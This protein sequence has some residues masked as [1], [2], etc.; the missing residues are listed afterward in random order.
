M[1]RDAESNRDRVDLDGQ[2]KGSK[3]GVL[4]RLSGIRHPLALTVAGDGRWA[5]WRGS[6]VA[7]ASDTRVIDLALTN[8]SGH[9]T[10][11]G[12]LAPHLI[13]HGKLQ[14]L[15]DPRVEVNGDATYANRRVRSEEHTSELQSLMRNSY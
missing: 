5:M 10:L 9:Y 11:S 14:R 12:T 13:T 15:T 7:T 6:A 8:R 2:A 4:A 1:T 3:D